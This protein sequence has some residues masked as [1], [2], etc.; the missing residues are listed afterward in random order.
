MNE[1]EPPKTDEGHRITIVAIGGRD[2]RRFEKRPRDALL[3]R[4]DWIIDCAMM[5]ELTEFTP[6]R[7]DEIVR[8]QCVVKSKQDEP[9]LL[10]VLR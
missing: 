10:A 8:R 5:Y 9:R 3:A 1:Y 4:N 2:H 6:G 7:P